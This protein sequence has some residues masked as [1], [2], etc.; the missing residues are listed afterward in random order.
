LLHDLGFVAWLTATEDAIFDRVS[1]NAKRPLLQTGNPRGTVSYLL[2]ART[3]LY[4]AAADF[5]IDTSC[6]SRRELAA[7]VISE[8]DRK[9]SCDP[10][11]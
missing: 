2:A 3:P 9:F 5:A 7:A 11:K 10:E 4:A 1:R 6:G 8:A